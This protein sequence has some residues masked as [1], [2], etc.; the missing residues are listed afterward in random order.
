MTFLLAFPE[1]W[2]SGRVTL[3]HKSGLRSLYCP[4]MV[5]ISLSGLYFRILT[6]RLTEVVETFSSLG[7]VENRFMKNRCDLKNFFILK[8]ALFKV[9]T[10]GKKLFIGFVDISKAYDSVGR[11]S[12]EE[13]GISC[14]EGHF[15]ATLKAM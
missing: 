5:L 13:T 9:R 3:I 1:G 6:E 7:E 2:N 8:R 10:F 12:L 11:H 14:I 4:I 15:F